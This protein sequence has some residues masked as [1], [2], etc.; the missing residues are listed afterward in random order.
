MGRLIV[1]ESILKGLFD[2]HLTGH[3]RKGL[4][5]VYTVK[6]LIRQ[7][8]SLLLKNMFVVL[9]LYHKKGPFLKVF[10]RLSFVENE[11]YK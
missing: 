3:L 6:S 7:R 8:F 11:K 2:M 4:G 10:G 9:P 5:S 1:K